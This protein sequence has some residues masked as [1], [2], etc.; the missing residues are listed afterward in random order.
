MIKCFHC[1]L[2]GHL[3]CVG[4]TGRQ[5]DG[6]S[7]WYCNPCMAQDLGMP[8]SL[9][10]NIPGSDSGTP[11]ILAA[12]LADLKSSCRLVKRIPKPVRTQVCLALAEHVENAINNPSHQTWYDFLNFAFRTLKAPNNSKSQKVT[13]SSAIR[14]QLQSNAPDFSTFSAADSPDSHIVKNKS[15]QEKL[16]D[17]VKSKCA[18]GDIRSALRLLTSDDTFLAPNADTVSVL[19]DKHPDGPS[20]GGITDLLPPTENLSVDHSEVLSAINSMPSGSAG[21]LDGVRPLFLQQLVSSHTAEHGRRLLA[22]LTKLVDMFLSGNIP[23]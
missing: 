20:N 18:D 10:G 4:L 9:V 7:N 1:G 8:N 5:A 23:E 12:A 13:L 17:R 21:G 14:L 15:Q 19:R 16:A 6:L 22:A 2:W 3:S 11:V